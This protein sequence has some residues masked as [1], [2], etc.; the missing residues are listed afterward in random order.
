MKVTETRNKNKKKHNMK[1]MAIKSFNVLQHKK[2]KKK[3]EFIWLTGKLNCQL[4]EWMRENRM[5][6]FVKNNQSVYLS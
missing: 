6:L 5:N 3:K 2:R 4:M 1:S